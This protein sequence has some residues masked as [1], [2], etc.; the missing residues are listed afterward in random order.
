MNCEMESEKRLR[1]VM[2]L[3]HLDYYLGT[4]EYKSANDNGRGGSREG[5]ETSESAL[6]GGNRVA[7][8]DLNVSGSAVDDEDLQYLLLCHGCIIAGT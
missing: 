2:K 5:S 4:V 8:K 1:Q 3:S 7:D 6:E